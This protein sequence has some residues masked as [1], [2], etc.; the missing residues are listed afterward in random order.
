MENN[1]RSSNARDSVIL[2]VSIIIV[3]RL[4][5]KFL[6]RVAPKRSDDDEPIEQLLYDQVDS[7]KLTDDNSNIRPSVKSSVKS[8]KVKKFQKTLSSRK[9]LPIDAGID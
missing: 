8:E 2:A 6:N 5:W 7:A 4:M 9:L 1:N 3:C